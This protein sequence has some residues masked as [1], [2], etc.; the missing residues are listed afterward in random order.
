MET[1][2]KLYISSRLRVNLLTL[3]LNHQNTDVSYS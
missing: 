1:G 2:K 3:T